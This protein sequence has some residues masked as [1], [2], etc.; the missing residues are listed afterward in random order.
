MLAHVTD[1]S[2]AWCRYQLPCVSDMCY[3]SPSDVKFLIVRVICAVILT[4]QMKNFAFPGTFG[5]V[6][7]HLWWLQPWGMEWRGVLLSF[8]GWRPGILLNTPQ[9][10]EQLPPRGM[11]QPHMS[12]VMT[13]RNSALE[14]LVCWTNSEC[15]LYAGSHSALQ[16]RLWMRPV[17][18]FPSWNKH[19]D[20]EDG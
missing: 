5:N 17:R 13:L 2:G 10:T 3:V 12:A 11:S 7:R 19:S 8:R 18:F 1:G 16:V 6:Q 15:L 4:L 14:L 20:G 9:C